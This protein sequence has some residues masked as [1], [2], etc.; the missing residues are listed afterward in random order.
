MVWL[1]S[2]HSAPDAFATTGCHVW[3]VFPRPSGGHLPSPASSEA[4]CGVFFSQQGCPPPP[5]FYPPCH[6]HHSSHLQCWFHQRTHHL[7]HPSSLYPGESVLGSP[8]Q[9]CSSHIPEKSQFLSAWLNLWIWYVK[10]MH[11]NGFS[12]MKFHH[13]SHCD[14][15][16][17]KY[18]ENENNT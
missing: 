11:L 4:S 6:K 10:R 3:G 16:F 5:A 12:K 9:Q 15:A 2:F 1:T 13:F 8:V 17:V 14:T 18:L 7:C